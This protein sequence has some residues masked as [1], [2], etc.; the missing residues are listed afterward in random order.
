MALSFHLSASFIHGLMSPYRVPDQFLNQR[1]RNCSIQRKLEGRLG[2]L[3][4][5]QFIHVFLDDWRTKIEPNTR[6]EKSE[7][8]E[9]PLDA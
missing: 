8:A 4:L 2:S 3:V 7:A 6:V 1:D 5:R 9:S